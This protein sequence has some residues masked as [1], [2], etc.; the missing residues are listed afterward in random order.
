MSLLQCNG[1]CDYIIKSLGK[2]SEGLQESLANLVKL[3]RGEC[4]PEG[5]GAGAGQ[6][7]QGQALQD[8]AQGH[9]T[10]DCRALSDNSTKQP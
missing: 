1:S 6:Q 5:M 4:S 9:V 8:S 2:G 3:R 7:E 10:S